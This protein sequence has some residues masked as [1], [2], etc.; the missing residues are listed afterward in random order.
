M[1]GQFLLVYKRFKQSLIKLMV[2]FEPEL[3]RQRKT[4]PTTGCRN[5]VQRA[6]CFTKRL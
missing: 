2:G 4:E 5:T 3:S 6:S 1:N